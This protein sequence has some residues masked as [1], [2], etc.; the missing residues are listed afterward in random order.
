MNMKRFFLYAIVI[1]AL[2]LAGCGGNGGTTAT[3][4]NGNGGTPPPPPGPDLEDMFAAAE[5]A[6][7]TA[8]AASMTADDAV[9]TATRDSA[10]LGTVAVQG[11]SMMAEDNA[12]SVL[13]SYD[14]VKMAV[15][16]ATTAQG[17]AEDTLE[18]VPA[19]GA[20]RDELLSALD[21]AIKVAKAA[22]ESTTDAYE[23]KAL[24][25]AVEAVK[26]DDPEDEDYP[27][28]P[29]DHA[30]MVAMS[31]GGALGPTSA[32]NGA[33][34]RVTFNTDDTT[35]ARPAAPTMEGALPTFHEANDH[36]GDTWAEIVGETMKMR[37]DTGTENQSH[38]VDAAK[39]ENMALS[40]A[41]VDRA[42]LDLSA[43]GARDDG[44]EHT[45][46]YNG[47][48]GTI[49][50]VGTCSTTTGSDEV[51]RLTGDWY[52]TPTSPKEWY[53]ESEDANGND[54][55]VA[56]TLYSR[57]G[58]WVVADG[59]VFRIHTRALA[60]TNADGTTAGTGYERGRP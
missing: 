40:T 53:V 49:F 32:T 11:D 59:T 36:Q 57:Y 12:Q 26:G 29:A 19:T 2:A 8:A 25:D 5:D 20:N 33:G 44:A 45:G 23:S 51:E 18:N 24:K 15:M 39:F 14:A 50:C 54:I 31:I 56:E 35:N 34:M 13:D 48:P 52:F 47:I 30:K 38:E 21:E 58:Y 4:G 46:N 16:D 17:N 43:A 41:G 55:Y 60:Q 6:R 27:T 1:A 37:I 9:K 22:V 28:T 7:S 10:R 42:A 3:N